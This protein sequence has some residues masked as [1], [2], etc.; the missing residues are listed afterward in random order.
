MQTMTGNPSRLSQAAGVQPRRILFAMPYPGYLRYFDSVIRSLAERGH[1]V[2][3]W[4]ETTDKQLEGLAAIEGCERVTVCGVLP[5]RHDR[6]AR[7]ARNAR[8]TLDYVRYLDPR[9][10]DAEYLKDRMGQKLPGFLGALRRVGTLPPRVVS[11]LVGFGLALE[12]A[13]PRA[14]VFDRLIVDKAPGLVVAG[15]VLT[16]ASR[17]ADLIVSAR[18]AGVPTAGMVAS[19]DNFTTK[20]IFRVLPDRVLVWNEALAREGV[21]LHRIPRPRLVVT[22]A[23]PFDRWFD[24]GPVRDADAFFDRVGLPRGRYLLFTGSTA[25]ISHPEAEIE[26]VLEWLRRIRAS[27][28][29]LRSLSVMVRPHPYNSAHWP[30]VDLAPFAPAVLWPPAGANPVDQGDRADY[31]DSIHYASAVVGINTTA[32]IE[33]AIQRRPVLSI[34]LPTFKDT[35]GGTLHFRHLLPENGGFVR[36]ARSLEEHLEQLEDVLENP[37][38][39]RTQI[40]AFVTRFLRP[41][42]L[43]RASTPIVVDELE[44]VAARRPEPV[45]HQRLLVSLALRAILLAVFA[46]AGTGLSPRASLLRLRKRHGRRIHSA[47]R[48]L[49][50]TTVAPRRNR[51]VGNPAREEEHPV[52]HGRHV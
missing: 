35:Q 49:R 13:L 43:E 9:F 21:E 46:R 10:S 47:M 38:E 22:G 51:V 32:M 8:L 18:A 17:L 24:R 23:Q 26:F 29:S 41:H 27:E 3:L 1:S 36:V 39:A 15:P 20:G 44:S 7:A 37:G 12:R 42:G 48:T 5:K 30:E 33:A 4:F 45:V 34:A 11:S 40:D 52:G 31:Y 28:S 19:W 14:P 2:D 16:P 25:S 50:W 6:F